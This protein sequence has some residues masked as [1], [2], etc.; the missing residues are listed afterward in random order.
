MPSSGV[1]EDSNNVLTYLKQ[2]IKKQKSIPLWEMKEQLRTHIFIHDPE[3]ERERILGSFENPEPALSDNTFSSK[4]IPTAL[5]FQD[6]PPTGTKYP[7]S[8]SLWA[9]LIQTTRVSY[10]L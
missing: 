7:N 2:I 8:L 1:S 4:A 5:S 6:H 3:A 10:K 9:I